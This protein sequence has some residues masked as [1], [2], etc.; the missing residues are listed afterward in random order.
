MFKWAQADM[1]NI[2]KTTEQQK[3]TKKQLLLVAAR[4]KR[5]S[6]R[7]WSAPVMDGSSGHS[8]KV[9]QDH[10]FQVDGLFSLHQRSCVQTNPR[11]L[12][13]C[14]SSLKSSSLLLP[15]KASVI[16]RD[17]RLLQPSPILLDRLLLCHR[18]WHIKTEEEALTPTDDQ[19]LP[20]GP[21]CLSDCGRK[22]EF[23]RE[24]AQAQRERT[25]PTQKGQRW[26]WTQQLLAVNPQHHPL[27]RYIQDDNLMSFQGSVRIYFPQLQWRKSSAR[28]G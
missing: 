2:N 24:L 9:V 14:A 8:Q 4:Y 7:D 6:P 1:T 25:D 11:Q 27:Q 21:T 3:T 16:Q 23:R 22:L 5:C 17:W 10:C 26:N 19:G 28:G 20:V 13:N 18:G 12:A 15:Y